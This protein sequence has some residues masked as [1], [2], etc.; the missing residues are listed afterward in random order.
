MTEDL[1]KFVVP[2]SF[3]LPGEPDNELVRAMI[4][5]LVREEIQSILKEEALRQR[6]KPAR[7]PEER[8][9]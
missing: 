3:T 8:K 6:V 7:G 2:V 1:G 9:A 4:R 5:A